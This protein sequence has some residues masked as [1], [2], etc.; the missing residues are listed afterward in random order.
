MGSL[1]LILIH[2]PNDN[3]CGKRRTNLNL[4]Q[5]EKKEIQ[6]KIDEQCQ[7]FD[8]IVLRNSKCFDWIKKSIRKNKTCTHTQHNGEI[9]IYQK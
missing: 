1:Y 9:K 6:K 7:C 2:F 8:Y 4:S 5:S 3:K